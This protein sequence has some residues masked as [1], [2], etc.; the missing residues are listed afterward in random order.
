VIGKKA[1]F[2]A[3]RRDFQSIAVLLTQTPASV[4]QMIKNTETGCWLANALYT[5]IL[6]SVSPTAGG[7]R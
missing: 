1:S 3:R 6:F 7:L 5:H 4:I 2:I